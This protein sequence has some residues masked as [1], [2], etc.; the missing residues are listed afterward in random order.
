MPEDVKPD[1]QQ[2]DDTEEQSE[3]TQDQAGEEE[4][5]VEKGDTAEEEDAESDTDGE[6]D[7]AAEDSEEDS[8]EDGDED[9]PLIDDEKFNALKDDPAA[10]RKELQAAATKKFQRL[11]KARKIVEPYADFISA[12]EEDQIGAA[13]A[14]AEQLG[15]KVEKPKNEA[16]AEKAAVKLSERVAAKIKAALGP[17]YEDLADKIAAGVHEAGVEMFNEL[18]A[19]II[20][21]QK[22]LINDSAMTVANTVIKDFEKAHPDWK[23]HEKAM[24]AMMAKHPPSGKVTEREYLEDIYT[25]ATNRKAIGE[26]VKKTIAKM[27]RNVQRSEGKSRT[28][29][30]KTVSKGPAGKLPSWDEA[31]GAALR[32][33]RFD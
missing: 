22:R 15:I 24:T 27:T 20:E 6:G 12:F 11:S 17:D 9:K 28:A 4:S 19:P 33:E 5:G 21:D 14:L 7:A 18:A 16:E 3:E 23:K 31:A 8:D 1:D 25:L 2:T 26:K 32:G 30:D 10:L 13:T 29:S